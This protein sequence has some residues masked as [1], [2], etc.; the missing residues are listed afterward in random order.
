MEWPS[1]DWQ[2]HY[3][4]SNRIWVY[5]NVVLILPFIISCICRF[6][7]PDIN[8]KL[9]TDHLSRLFLFLTWL[10]YIYDIPVKYLVDGGATVCQKGFFIHHVSSLFIMPPLILNHY[11]PWW[12]NPIG[13]LHGFCIYYPEFEP[14]IYIYALALMV[15]HY[16][17]YQKPFYNLKYYG[18][19]RVFMNGVWIFCIFLLIGD[20]S[21]FLPLGADWSIYLDIQKSRKLPVNPIKSI[22]N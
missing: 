11:I 5:G 2:Y 14:L 10:Y 21:N 22:I 20:C 9:W 4:L 17:I 15:F 1:I 12:A 7:N 16:G 3:Y 13:F 6:R 8:K 18:F 19:L